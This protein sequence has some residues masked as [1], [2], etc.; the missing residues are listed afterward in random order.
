MKITMRA[1]SVLALILSAG[2][3]LTPSTAA[4][5]ETA[6]VEK[7]SPKAL[8]IGSDAPALKVGKWIKGSEVKSFEKGKTYVVEFW[9]TWCG[10]CK[11]SIPHLTELAK[12][13]KD[14]LTVIGVSVWENDD[15][16]I[17][18][19]TKFVEKMGDKM[20]YVV[21]VDDH[22]DNNG[23]MATNWMTAAKQDGIPAS[24][25]INGE[26]KVA[27]IGHPMEMDAKLDAVLAGTYDLNKAKAEAEEEAKKAAQAAEDMKA[28]Q[29]DFAPIRTAMQSGDNAAAIKAIDEVIAAKPQHAERLGTTKFRLLVDMNNADANTVAKTLSESTYKDN[30]QALNELAWTMLD[31]KSFTKADFGVAHDIAK[32][33]AELTKMEDGMILD[34]YALATF[35]KGDIDK[36]IEIQSKAV[37]LTKDESEDMTADIK[38]RLEEFKK[39]KK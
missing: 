39:A 25:I 17:D 7:A 6:A 30:S 5:Q 9:A 36:A 27:W 15:E 21:A 31:T 33:A 10:P 35:K 38:A 14:K 8:T 34:T 13:H 11:K 24:F 20:D 28:M 37:E 32:R 1:M 4:A 2:I 16:Y 29:K 19:V 12:K 23:S 22:S 3:V 18:T 26:G